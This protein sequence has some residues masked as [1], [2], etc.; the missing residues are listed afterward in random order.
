MKVNKCPFKGLVKPKK[1]KGLSII[2]IAINPLKFISNIRE[3]YGDIS[4]YKMLGV[5]NYLITHPDDISQVFKDEKL[6]RYR[7]TW[8]HKAFYSFFGNGLFNSYGGDWKKQRDQLQPI[9]NRSEVKKWFPL[10]AEEALNHLNPIENTSKINAKDVIKPLMQ[11]I[12]SRILFGHENE[13]SKK[14]ILAIEEISEQLANHGLKSF[15]FNGILNRLPTPSNLR[16]KAALKTIDK[17]ISNMSN[18]IDDMKDKNALLP[19]FS[20]FMSPEELRDQLTTFYFAGQETTV[21][22]L[23][24][25]LYYLAKHP[26][27]QE[28][29]RNE[30]LNKLPGERCFDFN[31]LN[32]FV[33]LNAAIDESMRLAPVAFMMSRDID[34]D[35]QIGKYKLKKESLVMLSPYVTHRHPDL[36]NKPSEYNPNRFLNRKNKSYSFFPYGGG[37][38]MCIGMHLARM[39]ITTIMALFITKFNF[40]LNLDKKVKPVTHLVLKPNNLHL[41]VNKID[42]PLVLNRG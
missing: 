42:N 29:A 4:Q 18:G 14:V 5:T 35:V 7:K 8:F 22:T 12:M 6:G 41:V 20:K 26:E 21:N 15:I 33:F 1:A 31:D 17:S 37:M 32:D 10:I 36:W 39:E 38:R 23:L 19:V 16:Y 24:W 30:V 40:E 9:F 28:R 11:S 27:H 13:D 3:K 25:T 2:L 34:Q